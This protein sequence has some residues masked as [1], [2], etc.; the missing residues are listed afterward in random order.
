MAP[1]AS[2]T[3]DLPA[4][5]VVEITE[6]TAVNAGIE[7]YA[8]EAVKLQ[9]VPLRARRVVVRLGSATVVFHSTNLRIRTRTTIVPGLVAFVA[10]GPHSRGTVNGLPIRPGL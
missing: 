6:P 8:L 5:T 10:F 4:V 2:S 3:D 1:P 7:L 9:S